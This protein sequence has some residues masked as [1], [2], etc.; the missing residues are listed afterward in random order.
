MTD[1]HAEFELWQGGQPVAFVGGPRERAE[2]E[3]QHYAVVY[4]QDGAVEI[5]E[6]PAIQAAQEE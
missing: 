6:V 3:I 4:G 1:D 5:R 2:R